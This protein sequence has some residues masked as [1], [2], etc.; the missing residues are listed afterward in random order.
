MVAPDLGQFVD[1]YHRA[2][3]EF[4][5]GDPEPAKMLSRPYRKPYT[6]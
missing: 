6:L 4:F 2:L 5:Q 3:D 1:E